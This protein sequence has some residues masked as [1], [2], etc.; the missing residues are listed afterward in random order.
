[1][2]LRWPDGAALALIIAIK[3]YLLAS[4]GINEWRDNDAVGYIGLADQLLQAQTWTQ[5]PDLDF[6]MMPISL[7]RIPG[8]ALLIIAVRCMAGSYWMQAIV[9]L[10]LIAATGR[11][12]CSIGPSGASQGSGCSPWPACCGSA[13]ATS[14]IS[15]VSSYPT[16][17]RSRCSRRW[18]RGWRWLRRRRPRT[19]MAILDGGLGFAA[20]FLL[21]EANIVF[22][23]SLAPLVLLAVWRGAGPRALVPIY[24]P[25]IAAF[26]LIGAWQSYRTGS[27]LITTGG[28]GNPVLAIVIAD[29]MSPMLGESVVDKAIR[30][31]VAARSI[32]DIKREPMTMINDVNR[33]L[34]ERTGARAPE[35]ARMLLARYVQRWLDHPLTML[36][37]VKSQEHLARMAGVSP[38]LYNDARLAPIRK[39]SRPARNRRWE[40]H[41]GVAGRAAVCGGGLPGVSP[42]RNGRPCGVAV[43]CC[44]D[45]SLYQHV[46]GATLRPAC[47]QRGADCRR[48]R[49]GVATASRQTGNVATERSL[50]GV[51]VALTG[52]AYWFAMTWPRDKTVWLDGLGSVAVLLLAYFAVIEIARRRDRYTIMTHPQG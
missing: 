42:L 18:S 33:L 16:A 15:T 11:R 46:P 35:L 51:A 37:Y 44:D 40:G 49:V 52:A 8:Y 25:V 21:R 28:Q 30:D 50:D 14:A 43:R 7:L 24:A 2:W 45:C 12:S 5:V 26:L 17:C 31:S 6:A 23:F 29:K 34:I 36:D 47:A 4:Y 13:S 10:H 38:Y 3:L 19:A 22:A 9:G 20:A 1:M 27:F 48:C 39:R 32:D 41:R